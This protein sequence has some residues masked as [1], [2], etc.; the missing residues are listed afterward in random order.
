MSAAVRSNT[1]DDVETSANGESGSS[2]FVPERRLPVY[3]L[4]DTSASMVGESI[5]ALETGLQVLVE[6]LSG[7]PQA[8]ETVALSVIT[9]DSNA[10]QL[11]PLTPLDQFQPPP[12]AASGTTA[13]GEAIEM[14]DEQMSIEVR[15]QSEVQKGDWRPIVF[16]FTDGDP[17]DDWEPAVSELKRKDRATVVACGAGSE[18]NLKVLAALGDKVVHLKD[19]Q[20]GTL[21]AFM[22]WV[23]A[24]VTSASRSVGTRANV[25]SLL[26]SFG[27]VEDR[28]LLVVD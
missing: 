18:V 5:A 28:S 4:L 16:I 13:L 26:P 10:E 9:F 20:P 15:T 12:L 23:T 7:D 6:E 8:L 14:L 24:S 17:T 3:L 21:S 11:V 22:K 25:V 19:A 1:G 2:G 27:A